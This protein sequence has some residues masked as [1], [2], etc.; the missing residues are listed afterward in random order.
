MP[1]HLPPFLHPLTASDSAPSKEA[2]TFHEAVFYHQAPLG[3]AHALWWPSKQTTPNVVILFIP[4]NPGLLHFYTPFLTAIHS[5]D[6]TQKLAILAH[7]HINHT[8]GIQEG[9]ITSWSLTSQVQSAIEALEAIKLTCGPSSKVVV[10]GH[11]VGGWISLQV[12][13]ARPSLIA[14]VFLL[15]P[16][17]AMIG[18]TPNG[19]R[20]S[21][22]FSPAGRLL[23]SH[24]SYL[25]RILPDSL[26]SYIFNDWPLPQVLV[27]KILL[28]S[29]RSIN[30]ALTMAG[31]EMETIRELDVVLLEEHRHKLF[32]YFAE[33]D[34]WVGDQ[35]DN[36]LRSFHPDTGA[37]NIVHGEPDI[38][39]SFCINHGAQ[40]ASQCIKWL[41][42]IL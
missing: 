30:A 25:T 20:L 33:N 12:L 27:L 38:P 24:A 37:L 17:I 41:D 6:T 32:F 7:A 23:L 5:D 13:K 1:S 15:F 36:L 31:E 10:I 42:V 9:P 28:H 34:D 39:H 4:G 3:P 29:P 11:S 22:F 26:L 8:P 35:K 21:P 18:D 19:K 16:T 14:S 40:L 2:L